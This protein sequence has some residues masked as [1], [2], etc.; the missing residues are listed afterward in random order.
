MACMFEIFKLGLGDSCTYPDL[1]AVLDA[2]PWVDSIKYPE[3]AELLTNGM[4][5]SYQPT[6][7]EQPLIGVK[8]SH[9][10]QECVGA[11]S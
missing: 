3:L 1:K 7:D 11:K 8:C 5:F 10:Y 2:N 6:L 4:K 9:A